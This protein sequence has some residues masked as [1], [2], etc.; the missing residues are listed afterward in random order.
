[1]RAFYL[2]GK[3]SLSLNALLPKP[4]S[5]M[6]AYAQISSK[7]PNFT[8]MQPYLDDLLRQ[9]GDL[10][11]FAVAL[12]PVEG[13]ANI[14][15]DVAN[16]IAA[17]MA[18]LNAQNITVWLRY[19]HEMNGD[20]YAWGQQ[21]AAFVASWNM[22]SAAV[23]AAAPSTY[24]LWS[25]NSLFAT[26]NET[27]NAI[28]GYDPYWPDP[29]SV[30]LVGLSFYHYGSQQRLNNLP[31]PDEAWLTMNRFDALYGSGQN[32]SFVLSETGAAYTRDPTTGVPAP[33]DASESDIKWNWLWQI[34]GPSISQTLPFFKAFCW[35]E[36]LK[37]ETA[38]GNTPVKEEDFRMITGNPAVSVGT[39]NYIKEPSTLLN[40]TQ[41]FA[42][43]NGAAAAPS[44][45]SVSVQAKSDGGTSS[46]TLHW[47]TSGTVLPLAMAAAGTWLFSL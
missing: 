26:N 34:S 46:A 4:M 32:K 37:D 9:P 33:G 13:L 30:D 25:P 44:N 1:M 2:A 7:D 38:A 12:M 28:G 42:A 41:P 24:M 11:V 40:R 5:V 21:P 27:S 43:A 47:K 36:V 23:H 14:T 6:G 16:S 8:Q 3:S 39:I 19:A 31:D 29:D 20:W 22:V 17:K 18:A 10:P 35:F 15:Q 45:K